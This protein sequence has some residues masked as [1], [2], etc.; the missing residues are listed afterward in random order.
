MHFQ[1]AL[2][3]R[4]TLCSIDGQL[5]RSHVAE[6][7]NSGVSSKRMSLSSHLEEAEV[8]DEHDL[9]FQVQLRWGVVVEVETTACEIME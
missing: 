9:R 3:D 4:N 5:D 2:P 6:H 1:R 8:G 7:F